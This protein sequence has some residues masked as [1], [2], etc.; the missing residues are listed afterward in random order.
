MNCKHCNAQLEENV[1][2][3][4]N[5]GEVVEETPVEETAP[6]EEVAPVEEAAPVEKV[7]PVEETVPVEK[8]KVRKPLGKGPKVIIAISLALVL[9]LGIAAAAVWALGFNFSNRENNLFVKDR[10]TAPDFVASMAADTVVATLGDKELT[11]GMLQMYVGRQLWDLVEEYGDYLTTMGLDL[12]KPLSQQEFPG[13]DGATWEQYLVSVALGAWTQQQTL[14]CMAEAENYQ[15]PEGL[16]Q[17]LDALEGKLDQ[18]AVANGLKDGSA[19]VK[20]EMGASANM[21]RYK[22]YSAIYNQSMEYYT[23]LY[24]SMEP[25]A[26]QIEAYFD[27]HVDELQAQYNVAKETKPVID[28]RHILL[29]PQVDT[30]ESKAVCLQKA[31]A[32]LEQWKKGEATEESF[33][34]LANENSEDPGSNTNGGLYEYVYQGDMVDTFDAWCFDESRKPGDT[35]IVET[36][37]GYHIMYFVYGADE[38]Y[39]LATQTL[40]GEMCQEVVAKGYE[41]YP[42]TVYFYKIV[43]SAI[44]F[45]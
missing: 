26:D 36:D 32:L 14:V 41:D 44:D 33:A 4:P 28:V 9:L 7:A 18:Q 29:I 19:L 34:Q 27:E 5:C 37:Y 11:N 1:T 21:E 31:E 39:R 12:S 6:V 16:L 17:F 42:S 2:V 43:L 40:K 23:A 22:L 35:G 10:Y 38:W 13:A 25:D 3:C 20:K 24:E 15:Y 8:K 30:E 45:E